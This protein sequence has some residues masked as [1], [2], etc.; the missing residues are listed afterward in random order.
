M[1]DNKKFYWIKLK[2]DFFNQETIDFLMSQQNGCQ[3]VVLY[4]M[5]CLNTAN[6]GGNLST[7]IGEM[8]VP[9]DVNKIVRDT[10][11]FD[12]DTVTIALGLFK[13]LGLIYESEDDVLKISNFE[14][15]VGSESASKEATK[16]R[17]Q[18]LRKQ[19]AANSQNE[20][21]DERGDNL[22][23]KQRDKERTNCPTEIRDQSLEFREKS[24][25]TREQILENREKNLDNKY[26]NS[27]VRVREQENNKDKFLE[28]A[29]LFNAICLTLTPVQSMTDERIRKVYLIQQQY[30]NSFDYES[31]FKRVEKSDFLTG[32]NG[33]W[34][35]AGEK[36]ANFDWIMKLDNI[37]KILSGLY[38]N[39][40]EEREIGSYGSISQEDLDY[41]A[42]IGT[43]L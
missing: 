20:Q 37:K 26:Y 22:S 1:A 15:M 12:F 3:Y 38:D 16:K 29:N 31:F 28:I 7:K 42:R 18:R 30:G 36:K 9:Y 32:R 2:T 33:K 11:Y 21:R 10:K 5:L 25:D 8:I 4:Q 35:T 39:R 19:I 24:L 34:Y 17:N 13:Q 23:P 43:N 14:L 41:I 40:K 27:E 6:N